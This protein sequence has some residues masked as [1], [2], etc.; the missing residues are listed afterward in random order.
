M[1]TASEL[2]EFSSD[3]ALAIDSESRVVAWNH[4]AEQLFGYSAT[5][6]VGKHCGD[7][8]R[9]ALHQGAPLCV[10][11][12]EIFSCFLN[13]QPF[14]TDD[15]RIRRKDGGWLTVNIS[16]LA[17]SDQT[18]SAGDDLVVAVVFFRDPKNQPDSPPLG[19]K[20]QIFTLGRF[21][22]AVAGQQIPTAKWHRKQALTVL[23]Y[24]VAQLDRPVH[25]EILM[26][27]LWPDDDQRRTWGRLK[28]IIHSLRQELRAAGLSED[29]I[30]TTNESYTLR[31][32]AVWVDSSVFEL[33]VAEGKALQYQQQWDS[34][35]L[36]YKH[37]RHLY[38]GDYLEEDVYADWCMVQREQLR[39]IFLSLLAGMADC[40]GELG[41]YSEATQVCRTAL[42]IDPGRESFYR[43]LMEHLVRLDRA[44]WAI[45]EYQK[46]QK[47]L[48]REFDM[49]PMPETERL[50]RQ[51][52]KTHGRKKLDH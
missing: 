33:S 16:S 21:C 19:Q 46:C 4:K 39:E 12:C 43:A 38:K 15:C 35:L 24:L 40:Y 31:R 17:I 2:T 30:E 48:K 10:P 49:E 25:R 6:V 23:K 22:L 41:H 34:A 1:A 29:V 32:E 13:R 28:V 36:R 9:T 47:F 26:E 11:D 18:P 20:L 3:A 44:D 45:A 5:E 14:G 50:F 51:I 52:L 27:F 42:V 7:V 37:A 8:L